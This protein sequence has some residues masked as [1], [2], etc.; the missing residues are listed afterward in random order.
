MKQAEKL[1]HTNKIVPNNTAADVPLRQCKVKAYVGMP[2]RF[3]VMSENPYVVDY[4]YYSCGGNYLDRV[5]LKNTVTNEIISVSDSNLDEVKVN[6]EELE[7]VINK[8]ARSIESITAEINYYKEQTAKNFIE[9]GKRLNEAKAQ[10]QHGEWLMWLKNGVDFSERTARNFMR[11][12]DRF[13]NRQPVA[14]LSCSKMIALLSV[15]D[16][17]IDDFIMSTHIVDGEE[18]TVAE[19][20]KR[21]VE[22]A[23][24]ER[25]EA[26]KREEQEKADKQRYKKLYEDKEKAAEKALDENAAL[27]TKMKAIENRPIDIAVQE[28]SNEKLKQIEREAYEKARAELQQSAGASDGILPQE[29]TDKAKTTFLKAIEYAVEQYTTFALRMDLDT[30]V[31]DAEACITCLASAADNLR[32]LQARAQNQLYA[33]NYD[34][35][36]ELD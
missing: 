16:N 26:I 10:L 24:K 21:E 17:E 25:N 7:E 31:R 18:K 34:T 35:F 28:P 23:V 36:E 4:V 32:T 13:S 29:V 33:A 19:M 11:I 12:A 1:I 5:I 8:P 20:S 9:I 3:P 2:V 30:V 22:K 14:D 27:R 15:P 6:E